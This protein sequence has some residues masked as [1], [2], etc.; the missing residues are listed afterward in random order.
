MRACVGE[1]AC[2]LIHLL[3]PNPE[4]V[5]TMYAPHTNARGFLSRSDQTN[6]TCMEGVRIPLWKTNDMQTMPTVAVMPMRQ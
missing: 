5:A 2:A 4:D 1:H 3:V 6:M